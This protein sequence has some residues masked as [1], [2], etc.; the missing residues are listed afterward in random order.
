VTTTATFEPTLESLRSHRP[1][2]WYDDAKLGIFVHWSLSSVPGF[3]PR[4]REIGELMRECFG[5]F[6]PLSPYAE[7]YENA[8]KFPDSPSARHHRETY[9]DRPYS[10]F[11]ADWE[12]ALDRWRPED[13]AARFARAG[14]RYVVF[15][16]KHHD[17][18]CL[19]PSEVA[20]PTRPGW[21]SRRDV[22]GE[23]AAAVRAQGMRFGVYYSG[24]IDWSFNPTPVRNMVEFMA[25]VPRGPY[26]AYAEAQ[27][28]EL[29]DGVAP[30]ILWNDIAW[31]TRPPALYQLFA[32]YYNRVPEGLVN[33]R[34]LAE[35][36]LFSALRF[37]PLAALANALLRW[38]VRRG[39]ATL[40]TPPVPHCDV[41]TPEYAVFP[42]IRRH[43]WESVRGMDKSFGFNR[44]SREEDFITRQELIESLVDIVSKNGNLLLNVGPRGE[45]ATVPDPQ[46]RRLE[47][48][49]RWLDRNGEAIYGTRPWTRAAGE[50]EDGC[51]LRFTRKAD[52]LYAIVT[53]SASA[54]ALTL[55]GVRARPSS[56][57]T[58]LG[59]GP[60]RWEQ[61]GEDLLVALDA[62]LPDSP[63]HALRI[64]QP[65][66]SGDVVE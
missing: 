10:A 43:K 57:V 47:W 11:Q 22:V 33:D 18:Y 5:D 42:D 25:S 8:I 41:R 32:D 51:S 23:L 62:P 37:P 58:L 16:T 20:H 53:G 50:T 26:P 59:D 12:S 28:R 27:V 36:W 55:R 19:W 38:G 17:G 45:D 34:W 35:G 30:D 39:S 31:P 14:A 13:W 54:P 65:S 49:G 64:P 52:R 46:L 21:R 44:M 1:P 24:G 4:E 60:V 7:W 9:G 29:I 66:E 3:A 40:T 6:L 63:A 48:L 2:A 61:R 56:E 15:V